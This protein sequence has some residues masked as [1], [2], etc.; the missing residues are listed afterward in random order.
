MSSTSRGGHRSAVG[1]MGIRICLY[2]LALHAA[3]SAIAQTVLGPWT[4]ENVTDPMDGK[5]TLEARAS[6]RTQDGQ[7][8]GELQVRAT[9]RTGSGINY[10]RQRRQVPYDFRSINFLIVFLSD[11]KRGVGFKHSGPRVHMR[12][13]VD[14][15]QPKPI[16]SIEDFRNYADVDFQTLRGGTEGEGDIRR[17]WS[18]EVEK[19]IHAHRVLVELTTENDVRHILELHPQDPTFQTFVAAC[20]FDRPAP[21]LK[22]P[23]EPA[24]LSQPTPPRPLAGATGMAIRRAILGPPEKTTARTYRGTLDGFLAALP[25]YIQKAAAGIEAPPRSYDYEIRYVGQAARN[26]ASITPDQAA[27]VPRLGPDFRPCAAPFGVPVPRRDGPPD[28]SH[29][30]ELL[31]EIRPQVSWGDGSGISVVVAFSERGFPGARS[32]D[33]QS[34]SAD[35]D[36][37]I[38][39]G[40][41][42]GTSRIEK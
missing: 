19:L 31:V 21:P 11:G 20:G 25:D 37:G 29:P 42:E 15:D 9:C 36:C 23:G 32:G 38:V 24:R 12:L 34:C 1:R 5:T 16:F 41:I 35:L 6:R 7:Q 3:Q 28:P 33:K 2:A 39:T 4:V 10:D 14:E 30:P 18:D 27:G 13:R 17:E 8:D 26:C 40:L 22:L